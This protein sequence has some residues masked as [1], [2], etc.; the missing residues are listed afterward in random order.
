MKHVSVSDSPVVRIW[1][2]RD[3]MIWL[4]RNKF[5]LN[6]RLVLCIRKVSVLAA[7][8]LGCEIGNYGQA[9]APQK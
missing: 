8:H 3:K 2:N 6:L 4:V 9:A 1:I 5:D 7:S